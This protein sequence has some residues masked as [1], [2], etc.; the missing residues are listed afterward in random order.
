[1]FRTATLDDIDTILSLGE[2][3]FA[4]S[5]YRD[6]A[7]DKSKLWES[8]EII[9]PQGLSFIG[10]GVMFIGVIS[11]YFFS[12]DRYCTN[13]VMYVE[14]GKRTF[15]TIRQVIREYQR[16]AEALGLKRIYLGMDS[17]EHVKLDK[18]FKYL[19]FSVTGGTYYSGG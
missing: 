8:A 3:M 10:D 5:R 18:L 9:I 6:F 4:E 11:E 12:Y 19:G 15:R 1:M 7:L 13:L 16:R 2:K 14:P 17:E